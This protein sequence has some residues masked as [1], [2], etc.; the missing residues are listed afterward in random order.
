MTAG[1]P[2][3]VRPDEPIDLK[4]T[5]LFSKMS[6]PVLT[7]LSLEVTNVKVLDLYPRELPDLFRG[8][9]LVLVG[10]YEGNGDAAIRL[11]GS[12]GKRHEE[13]VYEDTFPKQSV[14]RP[15]IGSIYAH[16]KIGYLLDQ[17]RLHGEEPELKEEVTR[18]SLAYGIQTPYTSYLV[19]ENEEQFKQYGIARDEAARAAGAPAP[20][21]EPAALNKMAEA[22]TGAVGGRRAE[23]AAPQA[24]GD[25]AEA[26]GAY[27]GVRYDSDRLMSEAEG[28]GAVE[29]AQEMRK[30]KET[31]GGRAAWGRGAV[32]S[33]GGRQFIS[34]LGAWVDQRFEGTEKLTKIL[35]GSEAYF[36]LL[37][38]HPEL[39]D[40]F[41]LGQSLVV[42]T[43][44][45]QAVAIDPAQGEKDL[46]DEQLKELFT[47]KE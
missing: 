23:M 39:K 26:R 45:G 35:W 43:A 25:S 20:S 3:Y 13:F 37:R 15:F 10:S 7:G 8:S 34:Y 6:H 36:K 30:L 5:S 12:V 33:V 11:K 31:E 27:S 42:V 29:I 16:R 2:E 44:K 17:I 22:I 46:T 9:Q 19:L 32:T 28:K 40:I 21:R 47:D 18:L 41:S 24:A 38:E 4:V 1:L 14:E